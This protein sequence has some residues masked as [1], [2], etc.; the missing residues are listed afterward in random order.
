MARL[1]AQQRRRKRQHGSD[2]A[3]LAWSVDFA[4]QRLLRLLHEERSAGESEGTQ[5][6]AGW[7]AVARVL[8]NLDETITRE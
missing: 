5:P 3:R 8:I 2:A 7:L 1:L 4:V 6:N